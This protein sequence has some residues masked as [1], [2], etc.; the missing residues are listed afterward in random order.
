[1]HDANYFHEWAQRCRALALKA[2]DPEVIYRLQVWAIEFDR[3]ADEMERHAAE[4][5]ETLLS[6]DSRLRRCRGADPRQGT[7]R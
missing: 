3:E 2:T 6:A 5:E 7:Q 1:M 4:C